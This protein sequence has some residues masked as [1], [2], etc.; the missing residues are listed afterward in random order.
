MSKKPKDLDVEELATAR[1]LGHTTG[2]GCSST[3]GCSSCSQEEEEE[4]EETTTTN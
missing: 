4:E 1:I 2:S 3:S